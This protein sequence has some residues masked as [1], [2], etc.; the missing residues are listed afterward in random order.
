MG[1]GGAAKKKGVA[2]PAGA[3]T[4]GNRSNKQSWTPAT[5]PVTPKS[6]MTKVAYLG[7]IW[8]LALLSYCSATL[9]RVTTFDA[10]IAFLYA[11]HSK[12]NQKLGIPG[13]ADMGG[14][15]GEADPQSW[16]KGGLLSCL[17][18]VFVRP[19][20]AKRALAHAVASCQT[21]D[22]VSVQAHEWASG[23]SLTRAGEA[24][25]PEIWLDRTEAAIDYYCS[26]LWAVMGTGKRPILFAW[27]TSL[28]ESVL[29]TL[30]QALWVMP[31]YNTFGLR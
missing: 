29:K 7:A 25:P 15:H 24:T 21:W 5:V 27:S 4:G 22:N 20:D 28:E 30:G 18:A 17:E 31:K 1:Q 12:G 2:A 26:L 19:A 8:E 16:T 9:Y 11:L 23:L 6:M 3:K 13:D 10:R 14:G